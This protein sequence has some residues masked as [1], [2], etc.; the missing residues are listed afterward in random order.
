MASFDTFD[1]AEPRQPRRQTPGYQA[2]GY[3][4]PR[5]QPSQ[6]P[7]TQVWE[8]PSTPE[9]PERGGYGAPRNQG[10]DWGRYN[11]RYQGGAD[12]YGGYGGYGGNQQAG[13]DQGAWNS[14]SPQQQGQYYQQGGAP[15]QQASQPYT[16]GADFRYNTGPQAGPLGQ[17]ANQLEG[18]DSGKLNDP[19]RT[20]AKY[21]FGRLASQYAPTQQGFQQLVNDPQF[22][23]LGMQSLGNGKIRL[24]N[25]DTIDVVRGFQSGGQGWQWGAE[26]VNGQPADAG[27]PPAQAQAQP[28]GDPW[29]AYAQQLQQFQQQQQQSYADQWAQYQQ[30][31][32]AY[33]QQM[34]QQPQPMPQQQQAPPGYQG[35]GAGGGYAQAYPSAQ[36]YAQ[37]GWGGPSYNQGVSLAGGGGAP[38]YNPYGQA[39]SYLGNGM[40]PP[41]NYGGY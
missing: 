41:Y 11:P 35:Y 29:A 27:Q 6:T 38:N 19:N 17:Y 13:Y 16:M 9:Q 30:Q 36:Q 8:Q 15:G 40:Q 33:Q 22:R 12:P 20:S 4:A 32:A 3:Q 23:Q 1:G 34:Q 39:F 10:G 25:G 18:Y 2:P 37:T 26:T 24:P 21:T 7:P 28:A 5:Q 31:M 14:Y